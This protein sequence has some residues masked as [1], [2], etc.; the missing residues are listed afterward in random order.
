M[1]NT[2]KKSANKNYTDV[3]EKWINASLKKR[4]SKNSTMLYL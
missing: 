4:K 3:T 2:I 1:I